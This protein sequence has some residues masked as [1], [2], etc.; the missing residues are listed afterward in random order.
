MQTWVN[1]DFSLVRGMIM[2]F[3]KRFGETYKSTYQ[4]QNPAMP[5]LGPGTS[6]GAYSASHGERL[7]EGRLDIE[8]AIRL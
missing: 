8:R 7:F 1:K 5:V 2:G 6:M 3:N 4:S